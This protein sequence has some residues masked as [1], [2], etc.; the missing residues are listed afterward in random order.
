[1]K[2]LKS[3]YKKI[4]YLFPKQHGNVS[5]SNL[6]V[7][8]AMLFVLENGGRWRELPRR[9]GKWN[10][11]YKRVNRWAKDGVLVQVF[12]QLHAEKITSLTIEDLCLHSEIVKHL[13]ERPFPLFTLAGGH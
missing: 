12:E 6:K 1:M 4:E 2:M 3:Q 9:Y 5:Y 13:R 7:L 10:S 8:N 11:I